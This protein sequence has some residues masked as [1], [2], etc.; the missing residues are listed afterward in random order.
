MN[1]LPLPR[2]RARSLPT[3]WA[4]AALLASP[5]SWAQ[6]QPAA[7]QHHP[8]AAASGPAAPGDVRQAVAFPA[9]MKEH[10]LTNMRDHLVALAEIQEALA[11]GAF[12]RAARTAEQRLGM[13]SLGAHGAHEVARVM[14]QGMQDI[15]SLMHRNASRF[16]VE[17]QS[18]S[19]T[20]DLKPALAALARVTQTCTACHSAYRLE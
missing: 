5:W 2:L 4:L 13:S 8:A 20:G 19:A 12:D 9:P 15:G 6:H 16:A 3:T 17:A 11:N 18:S 10:T 1:R 14:P 7:H